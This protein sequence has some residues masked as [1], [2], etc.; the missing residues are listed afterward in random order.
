VAKPK[1]KKKSPRGAKP[2]RNA[3]KREPAARVAG[4]TGLPR[5]LT[6]DQKKLIIIGEDGLYMLEESDWKKRPMMDIDNPDAT[7]NAN[8]LKAA[9]SY[10]AFLDPEIAAGAGMACVVVNLEAVLREAKYRPY[11][12]T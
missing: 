6:P 8:F 1:A 7:A 11:P 10:L 9:G 12:T 4:E 3:A 5:T 2:A